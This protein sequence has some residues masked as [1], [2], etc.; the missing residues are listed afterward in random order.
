VS[1]PVVSVTG[2][3][4]LYRVYRR[5]HQS[6]KEVVARRSLG[7]W[8]DL[9]ALRDVSFEV[10]RGQF[11]GV[12]GHNGSGKSTLLKVLTGILRPDAGTV[13]VDGRVSSLLELAAGFQP[14]Y[15]GRE[16]VYLYGALLGLRRH[17]VRRHYDSIVDFAELDGFMEYPVKNYSTGMYV[18]LG[19]A[20][21]V[22]LEPQILLIDEV[23]AVG[24]ASFQRKCF[25]H[26][27]RLRARGC[28]IVLVSHDVASVS[29][30]CERAIWL[31]HGRMMADGQSD[32]VTRRYVESVAAGAGLRLEAGPAASQDDAPEVTICDVRLLD[33]S[34]APVH[35]V[36]SGSPLRVAVGYVAARA[37]DGLELGLTVFR[38]DGVRCV[39]APLETGTLGA[40]RGTFLLRFPSFSLQAGS[41]D[42]S[43]S[44]YEPGRGRFQD[45][46]TRSHPFTVSA[47][48]SG[49]GVVWLD[50]TWEV[51]PEGTLAATRRR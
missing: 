45:S 31:D 44:L 12:V 25:E 13:S 41:Y 46:V 3:S 5:R 29:R 28:T 36:P 27:H 11:M 14:E 19:F 8:D 51:R 23:L 16:N 10:P 7:D 22:H 33:E 47:D 18:R 4:K 40:G 39:D 38:D 49:G 50:Y 17:Q 30:F 20:V 21:A 2:L 34:G 6:I 37:V 48:R 42:L 26:L 43:I 35:A 1:A 9:W 15:T 24:D 32:L